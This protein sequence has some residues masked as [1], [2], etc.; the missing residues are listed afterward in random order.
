MYSIYHLFAYLLHNRR[1]LQSVPNLTDYPFPSEPFSFHGKYDFPTLALRINPSGDPRGGELLGLKDSR[2][3]CI[4]TFQ[5]HI[6]V[7]AMSI[8]SLGYQKAKEIYKSM[9]SAGEDARS[10][11]IRQVYYLIRGKRQCYTKLCLIHGRFFETVNTEKVVRK[12]L[13]QVFSDRLDGDAR[14]DRP[15]L[16]ESLSRALAQEVL[17]NQFR[18]VKNAAVSFRLEV[19]AN[20]IEKANIMNPDYFPG[21]RDD[22]VSFIIPYSM[23][24][25]FRQCRRHLKS[26]LTREEWTSAQKMVITHPFNGDFFV[27]S[28]AL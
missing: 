12:A 1:R 23:D 19:E 24:A 7:G 6:P 21:I 3:Y 8:D 11:P 5:S 26:V 9:S 27:L 16:M 13:G 25:G 28:Y 2:S 17:S 22:T 4:S 18:S 15:E 14:S 20:V 10:L